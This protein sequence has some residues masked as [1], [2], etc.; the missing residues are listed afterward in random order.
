MLHSVYVPS[1]SRYDIRVV[2][3]SLFDDSNCIVIYRRH[4]APA[5]PFT[6]VFS[7]SSSGSSASP[8]RAL[9]EE[10]LYLRLTSTA[11]CQ[12]WLV[13]VQC[14]AKPEIFEAAVPKPLLFQRRSKSVLGRNDNS[15]D[16]AS[17]RSSVYSSVQ[18]SPTADGAP[19]TRCRVFR[20]L[21][22]SINEGRGIGE[23]GVE[24][25]RSATKSSLD[26]MRTRVDREGATS[27]TSAYADSD[28]SPNKLSAMGLPRFGGRLHALESRGEQEITSF[29]RLCSKGR[30]SGALASESRLLRPSS[31]T[32]SLSCEFL[33]D[34]CRRCGL[35]VSLSSPVTCILSSSLCP[36]GCGKR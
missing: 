16:N 23:R 21:A 11:A 20:S 31:M 36:S 4:A 30:S 34:G 35:N 27:P 17:V 9:I 2:D 33:A 5:T 28:T 1:M 19:E 26:S 18:S 13:M 12:S 15:L 32:T 25:I 14:F 24:T 22:L 6:P 8:S 3:Y 10:P 7:P 29:A